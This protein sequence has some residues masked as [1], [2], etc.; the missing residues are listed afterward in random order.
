MFLHCWACSWCC[1]PGIRAP[2]TS[3]SH[4]GKACHQWR[5]HCCKSRTTAQHEEAVLLEVQPPRDDARLR[6]QLPVPGQLA[7]IESWKQPATTAPQRSM[8]KPFSWPSRRRGMKR[9]FSASFRGSVSPAATRQLT[10][11]IT[12]SRLNGYWSSIITLALLS[13]CCDSRK[14]QVVAN[15]KACCKYQALAAYWDSTA[16]APWSRRP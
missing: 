16:S 6:F 2:G 15:R 1:C 5:K 8:R 11:G 7:H 3:G 9:L 14:M 4:Y 10:C 13:L 12:P